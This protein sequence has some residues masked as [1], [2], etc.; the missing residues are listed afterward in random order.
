MAAVRRVLAA[1]AARRDDVVALAVSSQGETVV[2]VDDAGR[3][4]A[5]AIV[6]LDNRAV[7]EARELGAA[8]QDQRVYD[9]TGVPSVVPTWPACKILWWRRHAPDVYAGASRY[10]L[11]EDLLLHRLTGRF[12]TEGGVQCTSLLF[13]IRSGA[14]W[15]E[16][17]EAVGIDASRLPELA[18][19]GDAVGTLTRG[20]AA[21]LGLST[22]VMV[23]AG[24]M[25]QGAGAVGV[26]NVRAGMVSE[27]TGGALTLQA[28][29]AHHGAD[30][31]RQTPVYIHSAPGTYLYCPVCP[32]GGMAL[33]WFRDQFGGEEVAQAA[34]GGP[35][36]YDLLTALAADVPPGSEGLL[37][38]PHLM[39]AFSPE[40]EPQA[41]GAFYGFTLRHGKGHFVRAVL[42]AVAFMLRRNIELLER[43]GAPAAEIRSHGG[44]ARSDL[45]NQVKADVC[46][47][48][49]L[50]LE[51]DDAAIRGDAMLAGVAAGH[52]PG[53]RH[54]RRSDGRDATTL[55]PGSGGTRGLRRGVRTLHRAVRRPPTRLPTVRSR[56]KPGNPGESPRSVH[57]EEVPPVAVRAKIGVLVMA[58]LE[59]DYNKTA[60]MRPAATAA[61]QEIADGL[62]AYGDVVHAGLVEEEHQAAAAARLFNAED[63]DI[64]VAFELAYTKGIVPARVLHRHHRARARVEHAEGP[65]PGRGR[66]LRRRHAQLRHGRHARAHGR[67]PP[68]RS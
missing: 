15:D 19:P 5:P 4:L 20:A 58:L 6:W 49:V 34:G 22:R 25:D 30:Q 46:G 47:R 43:A 57:H 33:T 54:G 12:V 67:P 14:W 27:S 18:R 23:V 28:S 32:T 11:V 39:G 16:M 3:P 53:P 45:W 66:R 44:G 10:L 56:L 13:D 48:P 59:D 68:D 17:L 35:D 2:P 26:G 55:R 8:F 65:A 51:G 60:H 61:A 62:A 31:T 64:I 9:V 63:V 1:P 50:T 40:Y 52:L 24:G 38:L 37:M 29:V 7:A 36:A 21:A 42:E 41:R